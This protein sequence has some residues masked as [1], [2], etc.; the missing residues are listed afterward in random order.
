MLDSLIPKYNLVSLHQLYIKVLN[1][2]NN[3]LLTEST[4]WEA[5]LL[6]KEIVMFQLILALVVAF[7]MYRVFTFKYNGTISILIIFGVAVI[8]LLAGLQL[9]IS[10][11][12]LAGLVTAIVMVIKHLI[13]SVGR[14][15]RGVK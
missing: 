13:E 3:T 15:F 5:F 9:I 11:A 12:C 2:K 7:L 8:G 1:N 6:L 14:F 10:I 4:K